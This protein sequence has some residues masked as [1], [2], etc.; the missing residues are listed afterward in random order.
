MEFKERTYFIYFTSVNEKNEWMNAL[1]WKVFL[2]KEPV[3]R[4]QQSINI[5]K[6]GAFPNPISLIS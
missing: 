1:Q 6:Q 4:A 2:R 5:I 3:K